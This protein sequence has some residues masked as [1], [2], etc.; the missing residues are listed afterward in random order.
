MN[1]YVAGEL[2]I[3]ADAGL[4]CGSLRTAVPSFSKEISPI[5]C[6]CRVWNG[7]VFYRLVSRMKIDMTFDSER[8][9]W[10]Y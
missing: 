1:V 10:S 6:Q 5:F 4:Q 9:R 8:K 2:T 7:L 3:D